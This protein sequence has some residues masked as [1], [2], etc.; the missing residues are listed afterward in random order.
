MNVKFPIR[1]A[2][3]YSLPKIIGNVTVITR[4]LVCWQYFL[5]WLS[6]FSFIHVLVTVL[7]LGVGK[8]FHP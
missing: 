7:Q 5:M 2:C 4:N 1:D 6:R 8:G 3:V